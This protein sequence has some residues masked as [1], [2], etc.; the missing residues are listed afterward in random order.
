MRG[1]IQLNITPYKLAFGPLHTVHE[2]KCSNNKFGSI[3]DGLERGFAKQRL[4]YVY[5][6]GLKSSLVK[7]CRYFTPI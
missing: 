3:E 6:T 5:I 2:N 4:N 7:R 1:L